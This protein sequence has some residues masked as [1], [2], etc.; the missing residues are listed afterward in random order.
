M[1]R[2]SDLQRVPLYGAHEGTLGVELL[3]GFGPRGA[4]LLVFELATGSPFPPI[5]FAM[6]PGGA[7]RIELGICK[8]RERTWARGPGSRQAELEAERDA[9]LAAGLAELPLDR[10][11]AAGLLGVIPGSHVEQRILD[12]LRRP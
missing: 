1:N 7:A 9:L 8:L 6:D 11:I 5:N 10:T 4:G 3:E 2:Q 12:R